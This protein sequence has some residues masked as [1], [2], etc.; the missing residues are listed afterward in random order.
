MDEIMI[1]NFMI[2]VLMMII[3]TY[4]YVKISIK[5][6]I[7]FPIMLTTASFSLIITP[8]LMMNEVPTTPY[9]QLYFMIYQVFLFFFS[10]IE[11]LKQKKK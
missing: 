1:V 8:L 10:T 9:I 11:Y 2:M 4:F 3:Q 5:S 7:R 6:M